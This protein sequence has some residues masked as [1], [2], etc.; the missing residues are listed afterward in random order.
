MGARR[1][2]EWGDWEERR[3]GGRR[4]F[5]RSGK[6]IIIFFF[7]GKQAEQPVGIKRVSSTPS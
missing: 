5:D 2:V 7:K 4:N 3:E 1:V 6:T